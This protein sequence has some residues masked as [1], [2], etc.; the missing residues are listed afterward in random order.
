MSGWE[1]IFEE[2]NEE[3]RRAVQGVNR[4]AHDKNV[5]G[6]MESVLSGYHNYDD[7]ISKDNQSIQDEAQHKGKVTIVANVKKHGEVKIRRSSKVVHLPSEMF[8]HFNQIL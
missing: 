6:L 1:N 7:N 3:A 8:K 2:S 5:H 4:K